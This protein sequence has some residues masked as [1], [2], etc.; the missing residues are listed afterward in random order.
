MPIKPNSV[1]HRVFHTLRA[2]T[3]DGNPRSGFE[4]FAQME[5]D[6]TASGITVQRVYLALSDMCRSKSKI[7]FVAG[8]GLSKNNRKENL[9]MPIGEYY[10]PPKKVD[11]K[12]KPTYTG[13]ANHGKLFDT[14]PRRELGASNFQPKPVQFVAQ[15]NTYNVMKATRYEPPVFTPPR[16][17]S[18]M[19]AF[20]LPSFGV[21]C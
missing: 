10:I 11:L 12:P 16:G 3:K 2:L 1:A 4:V 19:R 17:A 13:P 18:S 20:E 9:Y 14:A 8:Q 15:P 6:K 5:I 21:R 7:A